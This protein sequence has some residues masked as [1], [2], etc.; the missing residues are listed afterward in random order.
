MRRA[1]SWNTVE[2]VRPQPGHAATT[3]TKARKPIVCRSSCATVTS[4]VRSPLGSGVSEMRIVSPIPC[5]SSS[6]IAAD[7]ATMPFEPM[8][9]SV[10][11]RCS[12][13]SE[14]CASAA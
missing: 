11:P 9:A 5:C 13:W 4:R 8:P 14:R 2:V 10:S 7:E 3:G 6:A 12:A 1:S